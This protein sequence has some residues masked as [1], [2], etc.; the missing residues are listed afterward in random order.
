MLVLLKI[1]QVAIQLVLK[2]ILMLCWR[3]REH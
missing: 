1:Y 2:Q 3:E